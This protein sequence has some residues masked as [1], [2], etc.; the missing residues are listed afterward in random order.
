MAKKACQSLAQTDSGAHDV[1]VNDLDVNDPQAVLEYKLRAADELAADLKLIFDKG[2]G[3]ED[4]SARVGQF[5]AK[6]SAPWP[7]EHYHP[8]RLLYHGD[9]RDFKD[10]LFYDTGM[11]K[12]AYFPIRFASQV[13][14][15]AVHDLLI[16]LPG[17]IVGALEKPSRRQTLLNGLRVAC[18]AY[19]VERPVSPSR[20]LMIVRQPANADAVP[21]KANGASEQGKGASLARSRQ[22]AY[23]QYLDAVRRNPE[24]DNATD[25]KVYDAVKE[26]LDTGEALPTLATWSKYLRDARKHYDAHKHEP[27]AGRQHGMSVAQ[28]D[29]I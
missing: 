11:A 12:T 27:R 3:Y 10:L 23:G 4:A 29:Q 13:E 21:P 7:S 25:R 17:F 1:R 26:S 5:I 14:E 18:E 24:L 9:G 19:L 16:L 20:D 8:N 28:R 6:Y 22:K 15:Q 2:G